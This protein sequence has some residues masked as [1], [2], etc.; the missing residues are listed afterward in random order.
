MANQPML[1]TKSVIT[2]VPERLV[3]GTLAW[4]LYEIE[5]KQRYE[6]AA[7]YCDGKTVLDV[8]CG[9]GYGSEILGQSGAGKVIG[10]DLALDAI[11][12]NG[13][14]HRALLANADACRL[15]FADQSFDAVVSFETIEH[16]EN[17]DALLKEIARVLKRGGRCICSSPNLNFQPESGNREENPFHISEM[18]YAEFEAVFT[19]F[20]SVAERFSQTHSQAYL[21]HLQLLRELDARLKPIRFSRLLRM[22]KKIRGWLGRDSLNGLESLPAQLNRAVPGDYVIAPLTEPANNLLTFIFVGSKT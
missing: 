5:H 3:A 7:K 21:R 16:V 11:S 4:E 10:V 1:R 8:A 22:E 20:F 15:P 9:T 19:K 14:G 13:H 6:W 18:T 2:A 17:P 12:A